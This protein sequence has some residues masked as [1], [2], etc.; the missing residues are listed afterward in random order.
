VT[1]KG[2]LWVTDP[3]TGESC[4]YYEHPL[5]WS[6]NG[7]A[8]V[9]AVAG[10]VQQD[11]SGE[12]EDIPAD[13]PDW[14]VVATT[15]QVTITNTQSMLANISAGLGQQGCFGAK[16]AQCGQA[17]PTGKVDSQFFE[18]ATASAS[19]TRLAVAKVAAR[20]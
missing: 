10:Q 13:S 5:K 7:V 16:P 18:S 14:R 4:H 9:Y 2:T 19:R 20:S 11:I 6:A 12:D 3:S 1:P 15:T 17:P 8:G